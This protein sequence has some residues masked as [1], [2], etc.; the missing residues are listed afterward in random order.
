[1]LPKPPTHE[2]INRKRGAFLTQGLNLPALVSMQPHELL[3]EELDALT[4]AFQRLHTLMWTFASLKQILADNPQIKSIEVNARAS[5]FKAMFTPDFSEGTTDKQRK[6]VDQELQRQR[7]A[8]GRTALS[9]DRVHG[10]FFQGSRG[11]NV[12]VTRDNVE[13]L[14]RSA[15]NRQDAGLGAFVDEDE[16]ERRV[17]PAAAAPRPRM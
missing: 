13:E 8:L 11:E 15:L 9:F 7:M 4:G 12:H 17:A 6:Q 1:M 5:A 3:P 10:I 2:E 16:L 14:R